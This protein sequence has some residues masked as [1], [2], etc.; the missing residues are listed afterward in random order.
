MMWRSAGQ[1]FSQCLAAVRI[2]DAGDVVGQRVEPDIHDVPLV[3]RHLHPPVEAGAGD[4]EVGQPAFDEAQHLVAAAL[5]A[6][7]VRIGRIMSEQRLLIGGEAEEPALLHRPFDERALRRELLAAVGDDQLLLAIISLVADRVPTLVAAEIDVAA[8][9]HRLPDRLAGLVMGGLGGADEA[10]EGDIKFPVHLLE[11]RGHFLG[12]LRPA[13][14]P[15]S[16][17]AWAIFRPCS[18]VPVRK[19]TSRPAQPLEARDRVGRDRLIG[20]ADMRPPVRVADRGRDVERLAHAGAGSGEGG[21]AQAARA[22]VRSG[23]SAASIPASS[24]TVL[25]TSSESRCAAPASATD[26][27]QSAIALGQ[28]R[29]SP[30]SRLRGDPRRRAGEERLVARLRRLERQRLSQRRA[31]RIGRIA[32]AHQLVQRRVEPVELEPALRQRPSRRALAGT[33]H[34]RDLR[35]RWHRARAP[36]APTP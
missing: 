36:A 20:M 11:S 15:R 28:R 8:L 2:A 17:A 7:E 10:I 19:K 32:L 1:Y 23:A 3:A 34:R 31:P 22:L 24:N 12:E 14:T 9:R 6:D 25:G 16:R 5:G 27:S 18:S 4:G 13:A 26:R 30:P 21:R 29:P 33:D 35:S